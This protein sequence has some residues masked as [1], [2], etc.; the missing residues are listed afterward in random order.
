MT[1][2]F[3]SA[4]TTTVMGWNHVLS[5]FATTFEENRKYHF[6][7]KPVKGKGTIWREFSFINLLSVGNRQWHLDQNAKQ[8]KLRVVTVAVIYSNLGPL[9]RVYSQKKLDLR[10]SL[11]FWMC[12]SIAI[13]KCKL[14]GKNLCLS[15][16]SLISKNQ[17]CI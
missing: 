9:R 3:I 6:Y 11:G 14:W 5:A 17:G 1:I 10:C 12:L 15:R 4:C 16:T 8:E 13:F 2:R 7:W